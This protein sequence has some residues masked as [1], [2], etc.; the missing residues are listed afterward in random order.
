MGK[1]KT[2]LFFLIIAN[3]FLLSHAV[4]PHHH[5][6]DEVCFVET[7]C[8]G[9]HHSDTEKADTNDHHSDENPDNCI[10]EVPFIPASNSFRHD[11]KSCD[12]P[13]N[14]FNISV[15]QSIFSDLVSVAFKSESSKIASEAPPIIGYAQIA[16]PTCGLRAPPVV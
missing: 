12:T 4:I 11:I 7:H 6:Q 15:I 8:C 3:I 9:D 1:P 5:H 2:A 16:I 10:L 13:D 14:T